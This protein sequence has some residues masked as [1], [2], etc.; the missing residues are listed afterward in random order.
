MNTLRKVQNMLT[1]S[2]AVAK[3]KDEPYFRCI[4]IT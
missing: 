1:K 3:L 2:V 4:T